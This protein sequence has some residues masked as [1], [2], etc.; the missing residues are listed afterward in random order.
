[1][2]VYPNNEKGNAIGN[3]LVD[4]EAMPTLAGVLRLEVRVKF[5]DQFC[6]I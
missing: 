4:A 2:V 1:L 3:Q 5:G 6:G